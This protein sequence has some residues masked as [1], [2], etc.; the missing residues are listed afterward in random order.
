MKEQFIINDE[1]FDIIIQGGQSNAEGYGIGA[2]DIEYQP[3][4]DIMYLNAKKEVE[5]KDRIV[6]TY[7]KAPFEISVATER[8]AGEG[9][10][11]D[12]ALTFAREYINSGLLVKGRKLLIIRAAIGGTGFQ[13]EHWGLGKQ[14]YSKLVEMTDYA[15][16]LNPENRIVAFLWHQ[17][18]HDAFE[19]NTPENYHKQLKNMLL[20]IRSRYGNMPFVAGDFCHEWKN[21]NLAICQPIVETIKRVV[22]EIGN[23][24]FVTTAELPSNNQKTGNG[25][26]LHFC[27]D[28][29]YKLGVKYFK[30]FYKLYE[31]I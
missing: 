27:R 7:A 12:F 9:K 16:S 25:D 22:G 5:T 11:G 23:A 18:E 21:K 20:D 31:C 8:G 1:K 14:L 19:G 3:S 4:S 17:G 29:L 13:K 26:E 28:S 15:L 24:G 10:C 6:I 30:E 2:V